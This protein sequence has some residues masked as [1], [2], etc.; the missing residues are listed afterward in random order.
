MKTALDHFPLP[1]FVKQAHIQ[2][3][4]S[5]R[6]FIE[7]TDTSSCNYNLNHCSTMAEEDTKG[8][9]VPER[10]QYQ[11]PTERDDLTKPEE[12]RERCNGQVLGTDS[13]CLKGW[14]TTSSG[15]R[16]EPCLYPRSK[17]W[18]CTYVKSGKR[19]DNTNTMGS[20]KCMTLVNGE[21]HRTNGCN[22][23]RPERKEGGGG[24][25]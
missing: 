5:S 3:L 25:K 23:E 9:W 11:C 20:A 10:Q 21:W 13:R 18:L 6:T 22:G 2:T 19:C 17:V 4:Q 8:K 15:L 16:E 12:P 7:S 1:F 14:P 24:E